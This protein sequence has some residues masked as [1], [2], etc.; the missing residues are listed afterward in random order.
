[1]KMFATTDISVIRLCQY[2]LG[3]L[4][5]D[6][7]LDLRK[8]NFLLN[9]KPNRDRN[10]TLSGLNHIFANEVCELDDLF[11]KYRLV[12]VNSFR[13]ITDKLFEHFEA[14]VCSNA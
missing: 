11:G 5:L 2:Y 8:F 1:M 13:I 7:Q 6:Y 3:V 12:N 10:M 4:P 14:S 9:R